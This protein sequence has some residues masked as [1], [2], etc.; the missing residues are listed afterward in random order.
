[1]T[2]FIIC[3]YP[4]I[5]LRDLQSE[6]LFNTVSQGKFQLAIVYCQAPGPGLEEE[7]DPGPGLEGRIGLTL[8]SNWPLPLPLAR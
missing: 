1:M 6:I 2:I 8:Q 4:K 5:E 3:K 7:L